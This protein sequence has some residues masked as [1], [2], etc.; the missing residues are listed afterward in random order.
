[1]AFK[2]SRMLFMRELMGG[3]PIAIHYWSILRH[4]IK[5]VAIFKKAGLARSKGLNYSNF[6]RM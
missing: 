6:I 4:M 5:A 3:D 2:N 1:M